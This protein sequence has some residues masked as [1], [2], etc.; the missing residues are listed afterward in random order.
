MVDETL[1]DQQFGLRLS[2]R[3]GAE[4]LKISRCEPLRGGLVWLAESLS[5]EG[6]KPKYSRSSGGILTRSPIAGR[7]GPKRP[8]EARQDQGG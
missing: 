4:A 5:D 6:R 1:V 8:Q 3:H 7:S 2:A